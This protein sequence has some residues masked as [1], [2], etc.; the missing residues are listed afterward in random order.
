MSSPDMEEAGW[1]PLQNTF[2]VNLARRRKEEEEEGRF[3][4]TVSKGASD[5]QV[6]SLKAKHLQPF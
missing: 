6:V 2:S 1:V 5:T 4:F 3:Q